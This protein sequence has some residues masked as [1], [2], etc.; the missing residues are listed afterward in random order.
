MDED[1]AGVGVEQADDQ[2]D[3]DAL[4]GP[5]RAEDHRDLVVGEPEVEAVLDPRVAELLDEV[6]HL[7]RVLAAV[8]ALLAGVPAVRVGVVRLDA[9]DRVVDV[10]PAELGGG[11]I[12]V[13]ADRPARRRLCR[14]RRR[15]P[16]LVHVLFLVL[17]GHVAPPA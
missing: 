16:A 6:D 10:E 3:Q 7:D 8:I 2:L 15:R 5:R 13:A 17:V 11:G 12:G 4:A 14:R 1:V 9:G